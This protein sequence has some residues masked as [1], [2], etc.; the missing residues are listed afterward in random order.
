MLHTT[1]LLKSND[2]IAI[3]GM[4]C[5]FPGGIDSPNSLWEF[6]CRGG[7]AVVDVP[8]DRW[9]VEAVYDPEP[10]VPGK[11][12]SRRAGLLHDVAGF[13]AGFFGI[14]PR[15]AAV[16]DP[17]QRLLLE[18]AWRALED[19]GIPAESL[20][21]TRT[22]VYVGIS[23][24]DYNA[25]QQF[26]RRQIDVHT[27]TGG[28]LSIAANRLSHRFDL[29]GPSLAVDTACSSSLVAL[30]AACTALLT[31]TCE[32]ALA[33]GVN[34]MLTPD[35]TITFSRAAMLSPDGR[36]KA[37]DARANGYVRGE[38]AGMVVLK[39]LSQA[40]LDGDRVHAVIR[41]T[42][43]NQDGHT[44][45]ITVPSRD[46]QIAMLR[47]VC[48]KSDVR[49]N[50]I[51]YIEEHG[52][53]TAVGDPIEA[54]AIGAV[55]GQCRAPDNPCAV[56]SIKTNIGH[57]EPAA[58]IAGLIKATLCVREGEIPP[59]LHF[60]SPNPNIDFDRLGIRLQRKL[61]P[62]PATTGPR[63]AAV[64]SFGFG[65]TNAC[66]LVE[67]PPRAG[68]PAPGPAPKT[69]WPTLLPVSA[70][71]KSALAATCGRLADVIDNGRLGYADVAGTL[72]VRCSHRDHRLV[73][74][75]GTPEDAVAALRDLAAERECPAAISGRRSGNPRLAFAFGGQ[76]SQWWGM[77]RGLL[78]QDP[79][80]R[81]VVERYDDLFRQRS[82][83][84]VIEQLLQPE[85]RSRIN[86]TSVAQPATFALQIG[87][88]ERLMAWGIRPEAV[89]GHS[90]GEIAASYVAGA[91][92]LAQAIDVVFHRSRLQER[93]RLQG[94]MAA[95]GLSAEGALPYLEKFDGE[96]EIAAI[97]G[98]E[99]V[100]IAGPRPL[101]DG[102]VE[103]VGRNGNNVFRQILRVDYAFHSRQMEAFEDELRSSLYDLRP[104]APRIPMFSTVTGEPVAGE[105][106]DADYWCCNM[107]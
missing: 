11:T 42:A 105:Q 36:C 91:L 85:D 16:M 44:S 93:S 102:L 75:A 97:N 38:G 39:P 20:A 68:E 37:F 72:A 82:G 67:Q 92:S 15:E 99:L 49:P 5:L 7:D 52:T 56:G 8:P 71:T 76:G 61:A 54:S 87:L 13:D 101:L 18:V 106:L 14:S 30:D 84:S 17:Q 100:T 3:V 96:L 10:G 19:A 12:V 79:I 58:G 74:R 51:D 86:E 60:E 47:E 65:G 34:V 45:T 46:A 26:G 35:V 103:E 24:S 70:A 48:A 59:S 50:E 107:R 2:R 83:W 29:R 94:G 25:I 6:L 80:F 55:F 33:G 40:L 41:A 69:P 89:V 31:G 73:I 104:R 43:V 1:G 4:G 95:I 27:A 28:A 90:I 32:A 64:N 81:D 66:A 98:P 63:F 57:L 78:Q 77:G 21:G 53:G 88:A 62:W 23:H 9:N 22:G